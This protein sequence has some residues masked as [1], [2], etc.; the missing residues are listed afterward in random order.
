VDRFINRQNIERYH[1]L[2]DQATS[3]TERLRIM[4]LLAEGKAKFKLEFNVRR[5]VPFLRA[6]RPGREEQRGARYP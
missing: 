4:R 3:A 2:A 1:R 5:G 6:F